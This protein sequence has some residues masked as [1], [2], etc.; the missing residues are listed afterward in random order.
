MRFEMLPTGA[1]KV[2]AQHSQHRRRDLQPNH[3]LCICNKSGVTPISGQQRTVIL[4][5]CRRRDLARR[6]RPII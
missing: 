1:I 4:R 5:Q 6:V 2:R 3:W